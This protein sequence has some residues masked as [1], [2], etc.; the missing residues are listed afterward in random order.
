VSIAATD[1]AAA[2]QGRDSGT[3]TITRVGDLTATLTV[4]YAVSGTA[5]PDDYIPTLGG[6][7]VLGAGV[8]SVQIVITPV[9][10]TLDEPDETLIL[11][12]T[13]GSGY[14]LGSPLSATVTITDNDLPAVGI[15]A[16]D[17]HATEAGQHKGTFTLTRDGYL[18]A[19]LTAY[20]T[21]GGTAAASGAYTPTL[22]GSVTF[23]PGQASVTVDVTPV[24]DSTD[25]PAET[26]VLAL[27]PDANYVF[28]APKSATVTIEDN[29][30]PTVSA[31]AADPNAAEEGQDPGRLKIVRT[32]DL[33]PSLTVYYTVSGT[34]TAGD[35]YAAVPALTGSVTLL[36]GEAESFFDITPV[37]DAIDEPAETVILTITPNASA[38][39]I[40][41]GSATVTIADN[42]LVTVSVAATDPFASEAGL[43]KGT[44]TFTRVG[45]TSSPLTVYYAVVGGTATP[46][47]YQPLAGSVTFDIGQATAAV[48]LVPVDNQITEPDKTVVLAITA[49]P[50]YTV[51]G[52][53]ATVTINASPVVTAVRLNDRAGRGPSAIDPSGLGVRTIVIDF[54][55]AVAFLP[56][57]VTVQTVRFASDSEEVVATPAA[58]VAGSGTTAMTITLPFGAA[59]D[60]WVKVRLSSSAIADLAGHLLDGDPRSGNLYIVDA[61]TDLPTGDGAEGGDAVFYV[62][63]L[64]GDMN[65]DRAV[66]TAD[67]AA[68]LTAWQARSLDADFR[69]TGFGV[70][71]PDGRITLGDIDGFTTAYL[72]AVSAGRTLSALPA[73]RPLSGEIT[74]LPV[75]AS[76]TLGV[77]ILAEAAGKVPPDQ[78]AP[79]ADMEQRNSFSDP[80]DEET[81]DLLQV[82]RAQP[83]TAA[84]GSLSAI[85][86][87]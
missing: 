53:T 25:E 52:T 60:T 76:S 29:D 26:V 27:K 51:A 7:V 45:G 50:A 78:Q 63:S 86:R 13:A 14:A 19:A 67:K 38:Y 59:V 21:V 68:F 70:R 42:D 1:A 39:L 23:Q 71:P 43:D 12:V 49:D 64:R 34:A 18:G 10:D 30:L 5:T 17:P 32:G 48:D 6:S 58:T 8:A 46:D 24:D 87:L 47:D 66:T 41:G 33:T 81:L 37:D 22:T 54:S 82:R 62:G 44:Y 61:A 57:D 72:A 56:G 4:N 40:G 28:G 85:L 74:P 15:R 3:F 83:A 84:E 69:G 31:V 65:L 2:E 9:D 75:L 73:G 36:P 77:D 35:D 16:T 79:L 80:S 11:T 20:Y 55:E